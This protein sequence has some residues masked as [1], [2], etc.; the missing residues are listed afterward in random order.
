VIQSLLRLRYLHVVKN[1]SAARCVFLTLFGCLY[2]GAA[3]GEEMSWLDNGVIRAGVNLQMGGALS[4]LM[5]KTDGRELVNNFDHGRQIQMSFY[6]GPVPFAPAGKQPHE[7][8]RKLGWNPVQAGDWAG[9]ASRVLEH[10]NAGGELYTR[11]VPMQWP[12]EKVEAECEF[13]SWIRLEGKVVDM[14]FRLTNKRLDLQSYPPRHQELPAVYTSGQFNRVVTYSGAQPF[15]RGALSEWLDPGPPWKTFAATENWAALVDSKGWGLGVWQPCTTYWKCGYVPGQTGKVG[16]KDDATGYLAPIG[17]EQID[18]NIVYDYS[19][20]LL[21]GSVAE[22]RRQVE[23]WSKALPLPVYRFQKG[24]DGWTQRGGLEG[25]FPWKGGWKVEAK[26]GLVSL[27]SPAI[28]WDSEK[29]G[30]LRFKGGLR[31]KAGRLRVGWKPFRAE[32]PEGSTV[33]SL[34]P[35][36]E[37]G[38]R[39]FALKDQ[40]GYRGGMQRLTIKF[41][42]VSV[43]DRIE[44]EAIEFLP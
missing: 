22:I 6:S 36:E 39:T 42:G 1:R 43:G 25:G 29:V 37:G 16:T 10:R 34:P 41:E 2:L 44:V 33:F 35:L 18:H 26:T 19:C 32:E 24:R 4:S 14:R 20:R 7:A 12:L 17:L 15:K 28:F 38:D 23:D 5:A 27:E 30:R 3:R 40:P 11:V 13:E 21:V 9:N 31:G 8:W